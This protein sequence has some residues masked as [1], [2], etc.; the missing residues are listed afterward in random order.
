MPCGGPTPLRGRPD[1]RRPGVCLPFEEWAEKTKKNYQSISGTSA[2]P[3]ILHLLLAIRPRSDF[4][5]KVGQLNLVEIKS[6]II[7]F[8]N[9]N[10]KDYCACGF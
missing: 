5:C 10:A 8:T 6:I 7:F 3:A 4:I 1:A 9:N 2:K